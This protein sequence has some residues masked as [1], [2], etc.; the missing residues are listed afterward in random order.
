MFA[1]TEVIHQRAK[2]R[3]EDLATKKEASDTGALVR[4]YR[5]KEK[6][7]NGAQKVST[8]SPH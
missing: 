7:R 3:S 8:T 4:Q 5:L 6:K 1:S 2:F